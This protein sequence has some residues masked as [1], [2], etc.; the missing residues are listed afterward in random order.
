MKQQVAAALAKRVSDG[1]VLGVGSGSTTELAIKAIGERI[2]TEG[3]SVGA[4]ATSYR[5]AQLASQVGMALIEPTSGL[6]ISWAFDGADEVDPQLNLLK[7]RGAAMLGEKIVAKLSPKFIVIVT[8]EKL[9][10]NLGENFSVPVEIIPSSIRLV[11]RE[12]A[13]L[14][15]ADVVLRQ[16]V[17]KY[18]PVVTEHGNHVLDARFSKIERDLEC[19]INCIPGVVENGLFFDCCDEVLVAEENGLSSLTRGKSGVIRA[20][21]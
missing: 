6:N 7:G 5:S 13:Q 18:G 11:E 12:L 2:S 19:G 21:L 16:A 1:D 17:N 15:A 9:V 8:G 20:L 3:I 14:G 10:G 4:V